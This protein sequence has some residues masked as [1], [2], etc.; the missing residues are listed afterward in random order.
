MK[1]KKWW[2]I[3]ILLLEWLSVSS[4]HKVP[5]NIIILLGD[6]MGFEHIKAAQYFLGNDSIP[7]KSI[8]SLSVAAQTSSYGIDYDPVQAWTDPSYLMKAFTESAASATAISTGIRTKHGMLG[9]SPDSIPYTH[10]AEI[11]SRLG[12]ATGVVTTVP[13]SHA[14]PAG[15]SV[16]YPNRKHYTNIAYEMIFHA[17]LNL[18]IGSG[19]P[20]FN[21]DGIK[22]ETPTWKYIDAQLWDFLFTKS[23]DTI[24]Y[25]NVTYTPQD[26]WYA[27]DKLDTLDKWISTSS[28]KNKLFYLMPILEST[29]YSRSKT[30]NY[31]YEVPFPTSIPTLKQ[32]TERA[33]NFLSKDKDGF[34]LM[35]EGG[36]IDWAGHDNNLPRLIEETAEFLETI[37]FVKHWLDST[38]LIE[39]TLFIVLA[40]HETGLLCKEFSPEKGFVSIQDNGKG[41]LP[42]AIFLSKDHTNQLVPFF[43]T[44]SG[45]D[46][47]T[48]FL[49]HEDPKKGKYLHIANVGDAVKKLWGDQAYLYPKQALVKK[50]STMT[51]YA[52][53]PA[54]NAIYEWYANGKNISHCHTHTCTLQVEKTTKIYCKI[55]LN[56]KI[57]STNTGEIITY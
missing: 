5:K 43:A 8:F 17:P 13:F 27:T 47:F 56:N 37:A 34:F 32:I 38:K 22:V 12:K 54:P 24:Q 53:S 2:T 33:L 44:G 42:T 9:L 21:D 30:S 57:I 39:N 20:F 45:T 46:I 7:L 28:K 36:A 48:S 26:R 25:L 50:G 29:H 10:I 14:T 51:L 23:M 11:A 15:F 16:H 35:V 3:V 49:L 41:Q 18:I 4:Q 31:P 1:L 19:H 6:G 40:D 55:Q 52:V